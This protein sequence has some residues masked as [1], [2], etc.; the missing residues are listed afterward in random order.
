MGLMIR[1]SSISGFGWLWA[2]RRPEPTV[3]T[4]R[5][6]RLHASA[7]LAVVMAIVVTIVQMDVHAPE[8]VRGPIILVLLLTPAIGHAYIAIAR[9]LVDSA[10]SALIVSACGAAHVSAASAL[11]GGVHVSLQL[12]FADRAR[13]ALGLARAAHRAALDAIRAAAGVPHVAIAPR[14]TSRAL[15][16]AA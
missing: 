5:R 11:V 9:R 14:M 6:R 15:R 12:V 7:V 10:E 13:C 2:P 16:A 4:Q 1:R 8:I 3:A